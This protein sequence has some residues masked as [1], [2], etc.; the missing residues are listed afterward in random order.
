ME[1]TKLKI[2][3]PETG[4]SSVSHIEV[5]QEHW[6]QSL[7]Q[8]EELLQESEFKAEMMELIRTAARKSSMSAA[9]AEI[10]GSLFGKFGL[11]L[12][13]SADPALRR[14]EQPFFRSLIGAMR[15]SKPPT[16]RRQPILRMRDFSFRP[17]WRRAERTFLHS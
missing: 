17:M 15:F 1:V 10:M 7:Q 5:G 2:E 11:V 9:F 3:A 12:L 16:I 14:L 4:R 6:G 8:L 13:D